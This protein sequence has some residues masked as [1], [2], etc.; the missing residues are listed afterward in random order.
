MIW[1]A[2]CFCFCFLSI[3]FSVWA[4]YRYIYTYIFQSHLVWCEVGII[5]SSFQEIGSKKFCSFREPTIGTGHLPCTVFIVCHPKQI[6]QGRLYCPIL[7][8]G[9]L[10]LVA[11]MG[12]V[13]NHTATVRQMR[14]KM[15]DFASWFVSLLSQT[16]IFEAAR[17]APS[18]ESFGA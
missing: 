18:S 10:R 9:T 13:L 15:K 12:L 8:I 14:C 5:V 11:V 3:Y 17:Q 7:Q 4:I 1:S 6:P 16:S 2:S